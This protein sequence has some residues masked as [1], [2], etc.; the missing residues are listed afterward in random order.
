VTMAIK[1]LEFI[2]WQ[3]YE[4]VVVPHLYI[5]AVVMLIYLRSTLR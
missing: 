2:E 5:F 1:L 4:A 3:L